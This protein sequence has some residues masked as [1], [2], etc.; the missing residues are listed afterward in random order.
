MCFPMRND[1]CNPF[2]KSNNGHVAEFAVNVGEVGLLLSDISAFDGIRNK[3]RSKINP[4]RTIDDVDELNKRYST[5]RADVENYRAKL[6]F[7]LK[8]KRERCNSVTYIHEISRLGPITKKNWV[9]FLLHPPDELRHEIREPA[10]MLLVETVHAHKPESD[11]FGS[12]RLMIYTREFF[13]AVLRDRIKIGGRYLLIFSERNRIIAVDRG[14]GRVEYF[15]HLVATRIFEHLKMADDVVGDTSHKTSNKHRC[16]RRRC[17][18]DDVIHRA[19][20]IKRP[21]ILHVTANKLDASLKI[22]LNTQREIVKCN[23]LVAFLYEKVR[24]VGA[25]EPGAARNEDFLFH[26]FLERLG[27]LCSQFF[28]RLLHIVPFF[29]RHDK[30]SFFCFYND[31]IFQPN[32][33]NRPVAA[34][35]K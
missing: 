2:F 16:R 20:S 22:P 1:L 9:F 26:G 10:F 17:E 19:N 18:M 4:H 6:L 27:I 11:E 30:Y 33:D 28:E 15:F 7:R 12:I 32:A 31:N 34:D 35:E 24:A 8:C 5:S 14:R 3:F 21:H 23:D 25:D 29:L 13:L